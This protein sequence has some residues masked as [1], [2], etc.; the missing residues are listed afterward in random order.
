MAT[1]NPEGLARRL[2]AAAREA[3]RRRRASRRAEHLQARFQPGEAVT[4]GLTDDQL[5]VG[6]RFAFP[7]L[8][9][10]Y[11]GRGA[12]EGVDEEVGT[13]QLLVE[14]RLAGPGEIRPVAAAEDVRKGT[15]FSIFLIA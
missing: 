10:R 7:P 6:R 1:K 5:Q 13:A 15:F 8:S 12:L 3:L 4:D 14:Q 9:L 11:G 2:F